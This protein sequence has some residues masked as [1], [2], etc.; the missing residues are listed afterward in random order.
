M[1]QPR[2]KLLQGALAKAQAAYGPSIEADLAR[3]IERLA[4]REGRLAR[5]MDAMQIAVPKALLWQRIKSLA[6]RR[7][8]AQ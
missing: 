3:A 2:G 4:S 8:A 1:M 5:C 7:A 6:P